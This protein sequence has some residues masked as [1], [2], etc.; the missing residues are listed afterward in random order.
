[1]APFPSLD[2][3]LYELSFA[4]AIRGIVSV[5]TKYPSAVTL[6]VTGID[7]YEQSETVSEL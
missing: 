7:P 3:Q 6:S 1:M 2:N 5:N 4:K